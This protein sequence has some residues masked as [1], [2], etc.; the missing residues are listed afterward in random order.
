MRLKQHKFFL[1]GFIILMFV[2]NASVYAQTM[3]TVKKLSAIGFQN[4][5]KAM[6]EA[7]II[8]ARTPQ[9]YKQGHLKNTANF[10]V[11]A[12]EEFD[13]QIATLDKSTPVFVYCQSGKRSAVAAA[14]LHAQGFSHIYELIGGMNAW[15]ESNMEETTGLPVRMTRNQFEDIL[16]SADIVLVEFYKPSC[17][18]CEKMETILS[19]VAKKKGEEVTIIRINAEGNTG[20]MKELFVGELPVLH[21]YKNKT[22]T[23]AES[24]FVKKRKILKQLK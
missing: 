23:W 24:G 1:S 8:D 5:V 19:T 2:F 9:E 3:D 13:Q 18:S 10:N 21:L 4:Q 11:L 7:V 22:L 20:L 15:R 12:A 16:D 14:K 17:K 6:P